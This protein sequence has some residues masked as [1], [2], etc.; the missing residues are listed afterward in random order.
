MKSSGW[1]SR[2]SRIP[3]RSKIGRSSSIERQNWAS[4]RAAWSGRPLN[5]EFIVVQPTSTHSWIARF[6]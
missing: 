1:A 3:S 5:S 4:L 6:Q 2:F